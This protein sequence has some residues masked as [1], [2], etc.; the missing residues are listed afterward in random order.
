MCK[1]TNHFSYLF[2][3]AFCLINLSHKLL[4]IQLFYPWVFSDS[5]EP[6]NMVYNSGAHVSI[7]KKGSALA[8]G[9]GMGVGTQRGFFRG[10]GLSEI[11]CNHRD[12]PSAQKRKDP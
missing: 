8:E 3:P 7:S 11:T 1:K 10:P 9:A 5:F 4:S 2:Q 6:P 12:S